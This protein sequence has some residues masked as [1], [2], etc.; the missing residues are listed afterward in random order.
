MANGA[1]RGKCN[2]GVAQNEPGG[3]TRALVHG[4]T[5]PGS[6]LEFRFFLKPQPHVH[7]LGALWPL[8]ALGLQQFAESGGLIHVF[9]ASEGSA[10]EKIGGIGGRWARFP[11]KPWLVL[12]CTS[13]KTTLCK[14]VSHLT[15]GLPLLLRKGNPQN[16]GGYP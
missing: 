2:M 16:Q 11:E 9:E 7:Q 10:S 4:S 15:Q 1:I 14:G 3:V 13:P 12:V 5:Y 6:I 8:G